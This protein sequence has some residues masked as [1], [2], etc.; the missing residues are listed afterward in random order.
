M[1][2]SRENPLIFEEVA[3]TYHCKGRELTSVTRQVHHYFPEFNAD[4]A[5]KKMMRSKN[6]INSKYYGMEPQEIKDLW[7]KNRDDA[8]SLG[9]KMHKHIEDYMTTLENNIANNLKMIAREDSYREFTLFEDFWIDYRINNPSMRHWASEP[10]IYDEDA[11]IAGSVDEITKDEITGDIDIL[12]W[13]RSKEIKMDNP[14]EKGYY[15]FNNLPHCNYWHYCLQLNFYRMILERKYSRL[16]RKVRRM[17]L[18]IL[19]P[20][21]DRYIYIKVPFMDLEDLWDGLYKY[22]L[23]NVT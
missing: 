14:F 7:E 2:L 21:Q 13:K 11:G 9:T 6:W 5:I 15:P 8:A 10:R 3:H 12:D 16:F 18:V 17:G 4:L 22:R 19:H 20:Q 1:E 23:D